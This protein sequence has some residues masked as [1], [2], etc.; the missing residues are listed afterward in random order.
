MDVFSVTT[1]LAGGAVL[2]FSLTSEAVPAAV[3]LV[4]AVNGEASAGA[5]RESASGDVAPVV[6]FFG[7]RA[8]IFNPSGLAVSPTGTVAISVFDGGRSNP[9]RIQLYARG[10]SG[11][12]PPVATISCAG[13]GGSPQQ[14]AF[15][16]QANLYALY[17]GYSGRDGNAIE[18]FAPNEQSGCVKDEH[19]IVGRRTGISGIGA[20]TV[21]RGTIYNGSFGAV[22]EFRTSDNGDVTPRNILLGPNTG[23]QYV[24]SLAVDNGGFLYVAN[25]TSNAAGV[26]IFNPSARGDVAPIGAIKGNRTLMHYVTGVAVSRD[27]RIFVAASSTTTQ[28]DEILVF[29]KGSR[30]NV[31]PIQVISGSNTGIDR[32]SELGLRE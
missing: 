31:A 13:L 15:D 7:D 28:V 32:I 21:G 20:I 2:A 10:A 18:M 16:A 26:L 3:P 4:Y 12:V 6:N 29:A 24:N 11:N 1:A 14:I 30:G 22:R 27:G 17:A 23:L 5:F 25:S 9:G 19:V 8:R